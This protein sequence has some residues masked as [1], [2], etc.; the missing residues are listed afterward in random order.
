V[1]GADPAD[2]LLARIAAL[3]AERDRLRREIACERLD[4][5]AAPPG[6]MRDP[7]GFAT[8]LGALVRLEGL[9]DENGGLVWHWYIDACDDGDPSQ[10][11]PTALAAMEAADAARGTRGAGD[12]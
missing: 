7:E 9:R 1:I 8:R 11:A 6:W 4:V 3:E 10:V 5:R 2:V 12:E